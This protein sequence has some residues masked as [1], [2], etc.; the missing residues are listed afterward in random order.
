MDVISKLEME[1]CRQ[2]VMTLS[3]LAMVA[4]GEEKR[5][6]APNRIGAAL[7]NAPE[8]PTPLGG[9]AKQ[10]TQV[11]TAEKAIRRAARF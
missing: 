7:R 4:R 5:R 2:K 11:K 10:K 6:T 1:G 3:L 9:A 8:F